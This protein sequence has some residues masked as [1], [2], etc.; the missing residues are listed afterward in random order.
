MLAAKR[1]QH[2]HFPSLHIR[3]RR[4]IRM[5]HHHAPRPRRHRLLQ[6]RKIYLPAMVINQRI[7]NQ[8]HILQIRQ[9]LKERITRLRHQQLVSRVAQ[10]AK[11]ERIPLAGACGQNDLLR[12]HIDP[13]RRDVACNVSAAR[14]TLAVVTGHRLAREKQPL[15]L[16][17]VVQRPWRSE[18]PQNR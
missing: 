8:P 4:I 15:R 2:P 16:R 18:R 11:H 3:S 13:T 9:K 10:Q 7:R 5:D 17:I 14:A 12:I 6:R 1:I